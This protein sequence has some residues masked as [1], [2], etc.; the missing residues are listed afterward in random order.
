MLISRTLVSVHPLYMYLSL[1]IYIYTYT[2]STCVYIYIYIYIYTQHYIYIYIYT[3]ISLSFWDAPSPLPR[4]LRHRDSCEPGLCF[5]FQRNSC[6][7]FA[8][9]RGDF[10]FPAKPGAPLHSIS[11]VQFLWKLCGDSGRL[12]SP[13]CHVTDKYRGD[14][15]RRNND[16]DNEIE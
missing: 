1:Y 3:H 15:R 10:H 6:G 7:S 2:Y 12:S 5:F 13:P 16:N 9:I 4:S 11:S 8:E 14:P